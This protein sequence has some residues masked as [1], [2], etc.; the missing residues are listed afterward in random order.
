MSWYRPQ[1]LKLSVPL[2]RNAWNKFKNVSVQRV[3]DRGFCTVLSRLRLTERVNGSEKFKELRKSRMC[4]ETGNESRIQWW[5]DYEWKFYVTFKPLM[6][7]LCIHRMNLNIKFI[8]CICERITSVILPNKV[9]STCQVHS[10]N[11][12]PDIINSFFFNIS[13]NTQFYNFY[14]FFILNNIKIIIS[15]NV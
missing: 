11:T 3:N 7:Y 10:N 5:K 2:G 9:S 6:W 8:N 13:L 4:E 15:I 1:A 12:S 14:V